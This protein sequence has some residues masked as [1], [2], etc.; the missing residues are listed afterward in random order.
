VNRASLAHE[1]RPGAPPPRVTALRL[2]GPGAENARGRFTAP[3]GATF[4]AGAAAYA[5]ALGPED[6]TDVATVARVLP[7][8]DELPGGTLLVVLPQVALPPSLA[9]RFLAALG[10]GRTVSRA[11]RSTALVARGFVRVAAGVDRESRSDL[12]WGYSPTTERD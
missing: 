9:S 3:L 10:R 4:E 5:V 7:A 8:P 1:H 6:I 12:V 11:L 2:V